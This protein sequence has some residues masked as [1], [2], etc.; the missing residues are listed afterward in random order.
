MQCRC[1]PL[2]VRVR[3][4]S[5]ASVMNGVLERPSCTPPVATPQ[6]SLCTVRS[7][8][9]PSPCPWW[10]WWVWPRSGRPTRPRR[11]TRA[12]PS[13]RRTSSTASRGARPPRRSRCGRAT[14]CRRYGTHAPEGLLGQPVSP[15]PGQGR[16]RL[17]GVSAA[18]RAVG[19]ATVVVACAA[20]LAPSSAT[21]SSAAATSTTGHA[22]THIRVRAALRALP[23]AEH[24]HDGRL[25]P[26]EAVRRLD[27]PARR[28]R[29]PRRRADP[30]VPEAG[31]DELLLHR[32]QGQVVLLLQRPRTTRTPTAATIQI[33]HT[34]PVQNAWVSGAWR[35]TKATRV[36]YF[37]D[38][39]D[40]AHPGRRRRPR[41]RG[42]GRPGP[43]QPGCPAT[44][45]AATS[46]T[47]SPSRPGGISASPPR[48]RRS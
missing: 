18:A 45:G 13:S 9:S 17:R 48:R 40:A 34:V 16:D 6:E 24:S 25:R 1:S 38:L 20:V 11:A 39:E 3:D 10:R 7:V 30:G 2:V 19:V 47:G 46:A 33:D 29:H 28:V 27:H 21:P 12:A 8:R 26:R 32:V 36:R 5:R 41:Q 42:Q 23:V 44:A 37:N 22:P 4:H 31:H 15:R 14:G 35:W 43:D